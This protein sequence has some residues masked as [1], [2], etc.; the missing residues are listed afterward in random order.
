M[1][2]LDTF[3]EQLNE[4]DETQVVGEVHGETVVA[5]TRWQ[6]RALIS[7]ARA[8]L[9]QRG[10]QPGDRVVLVAPNSGRWVAADLS[11]LAQGA[12]VVPMYARQDP[13]ELV[14]MIQDCEPVLV[15]VATEALEE[16]LAANGCAVPRVTFD[17]L[18]ADSGEASDPPV[19][20]WEDDDIVTII[21]TSGTSGVP[22]G[23]M[24]TA[25]N[26]A[27]MLPVTA[28]ALVAMMGERA[29]PDRVFHYLPFCFAGSRV[30]LWTCLL[31]GNPIHVSTDLD[32]LGQELATVSPHYLLNVPMLLERIRGKVEAGIR[33]RA[34]PIQTLYRRARDAYARLA[35]GQGRW[36]DALAVDLGKRILFSKIKQKVGPDLECLIC[37]SAPL[38]ADTQRWFEM[39]GI[40]VYQVYGLT[41]TTAIVT[42]DEPPHVVAGR[43]GRAIAGVET[44]VSEGGELLVRGPNVFAGY[45]KRPE[46]TEDAF[47]DGWFHTG[48]QVEEE[49]GSFR[50]V[51]RAKN[52]LVL[53]SGHNVA[54]EPIE[55]KILGNIEGVEQAVVVGHGRSSLGVLIGGDVS[56]EDVEAGLDLLNEGLP[57]YRKV[58]RFHHVEEP[59]SIENGLL[60][61]NRKLR[62]AVIEAHH[63]ASIE[64]M[65][66]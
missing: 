42:M 61:A 26:V 19:H 46:A 10:V 22:K 2:F 47:T 51:G 44:R 63:S 35:R 41:E 43:V 27:H 50:I 14:E 4:D 31:R 48:D 45:W 33:Q 18:F 8:T 13:A 5:N 32:N 6:M 1:S 64:A 56:P 65:Y 40:P 28:D 58:R 15:L 52:L 11:A 59:F 25:A 66:A 55:Q 3:F 57:H 62:R 7:T 53:S 36:G 20:S 30:V 38:G 29:E 34:A 37:G 17:T 54:P 24:L 39:L 9:R 49:E 60:T 23:V 12:I 21:Y 16:S